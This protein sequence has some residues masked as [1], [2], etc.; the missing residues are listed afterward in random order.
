MMTA[1]DIEERMFSQI[2]RALIACQFY[3][4][5]FTHVV[6]QVFQ[7]PMPSTVTDVDPL[8]HTSFRVPTTALINELKKHVSVNPS[9]EAR[10]R[11]LVDS[12]HTLVHRWFLEHGAPTTTVEM[13]SLTTFANTVLENATEISAV[14]LKYSIE[15]VSKIP[16]TPAKLDEL[17]S[18]NETLLTLLGTKLSI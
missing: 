5:L 3:E 13:E 15:W 17:K 4:F 18:A 7:Q 6:K 14:L 16:D 10:L 8:D 2:G 11:S 9:F 1:K 12:R